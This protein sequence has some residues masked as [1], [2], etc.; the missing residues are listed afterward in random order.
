MKRKNISFLFTLATIFSFTTSLNVAIAALTS[1]WQCAKTVWVDPGFLGD[2]LGTQEEP[3]NT[4]SKAI[5]SSGS[6]TCINLKSG[7]Y[8][9]TVIL[10][11]D[12][13]RLQ[14]APNALPL[15]TGLI[16]VRDWVKST[17]PGSGL[18]VY[19]ASVKSRPVNLFSLN[20]G[21]YSKRSLSHFPI[22]GWN[23]ISSVQFNTPQSTISISDPARLKTKHSLVGA[24]IQLYSFANGAAWV[25]SITSHDQ[26]NGV[27]SFK[28][29]TK[30]ANES[31][32]GSKITNRDS[33]L[34]TNSPDMLKAGEWAVVAKKDGTY[35]IVYAPLNLTASELP[36]LEMQSSGS[37]LVYIR[38]RGAIVSGVTIFGSRNN[39]IV[40][41][42][43]D[44][45]LENSVIAYSNGAGVVT[46]LASG[47][48]YPAN[49]KISRN[50]IVGNFVGLSLN[51]YD[52]I[53][54]VENEIMHNLSDAIDLACTVRACNDAKINSNY[55]H[56]HSSALLHGDHFQ[57]WGSINGVEFNSNVSMFGTQLF[58]TA[59]TGAPV[60]TS[61]IANINVRNN[62]FAV[63]SAAA[64]LPWTKSVGTPYNIYN[65]TIALSTY[66]I[67]QPFQYGNYYLRNNVLGG[68]IDENSTYPHKLVSDNNLFA[69]TGAVGSYSDPTIRFFKFYNDVL[70]W[71]KAT[72]LDWNSA[73]SNTKLFVNMPET[74]SSIRMEN[75]D[76]Q[77]RTQVIV[78]T[79]VKFK[80]G[81][82][83][84]FNMEG[85]RR[86]V[87]AIGAN[88][89]IVFTPALTRKLFG[90]VTVENW[91]SNSTVLTRDASLPPNSI[92]QT[93]SANRDMVGTNISL[94]SYAKG[95]FGYSTRV[96]PTIPKSIKTAL[97]NEKDTEFYFY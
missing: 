16:P 71:A 40:A 97:P 1:N 34:I 72:S 37:S 54:V 64:L 39:A 91:K 76:S 45:R 81:D 23:Q 86:K 67:M 36:N 59:G 35:D 9:E 2:Q 61:S 4:I 68:S 8:R 19:I 29:N 70:T 87:T 78:L 32:F 69:P 62:L 14:A 77:S 83:I 48:T 63:A 20:N 41:Y 46:S 6:R 30:N 93:L 3:Y 58:Y 88:G 11:K 79:P 96:I 92:G 89:L 74:V 5:S 57:A 42:E 12:M 27:I 26:I 17:V 28:Y 25:K 65:N 21:V 84:E 73:R 60:G 24:S 33:Y 38:S 43:G 95:K 75:M 47:T 51:D 49:V 52:K 22:E 15:L 56:H 85:V 94:D 66:S 18:S 50:V 55:I 80:V 7:V 10:N 53:N 82:Y 90:P 13:L 44:F 31:H